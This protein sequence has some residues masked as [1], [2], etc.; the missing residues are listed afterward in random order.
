MSNEPFTLPENMTEA[1]AEYWRLREQRIFVEGGEGVIVSG[2]GTGPAFDLS[3]P[4]MPPIGVV[5]TELAETS[6]SSM[7]DYTPA[8]LY[9]ASFKWSDEGFTVDEA[10]NKY[11]D[12][13]P[14]ADIATV[15]SSIEEVAVSLP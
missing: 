9:L 11:M 1:Q 8:R 2:V 15:R 5:T 12:L 3:W 13:H 14:E 4:G 10:V 6:V 7:A